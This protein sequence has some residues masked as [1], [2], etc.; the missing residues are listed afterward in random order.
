MK[1]DVFQGKQE[2]NYVTVNVEAGAL[3]ELRL[4]ACNKGGEALGGGYI[5][6]LTPDGKLRRSACCNIPGIQTDCYG[7]ILIDE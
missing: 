3:G 5:L 6:V 4:F 1:F 2:R 7:K